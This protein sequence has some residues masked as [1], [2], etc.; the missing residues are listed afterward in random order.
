M[1]AVFRFLRR[2]VFALAIL[3]SAAVSFCFPDCFR[4]WGGVKLTSLVVPANVFSIWMNFSGSV[5]ANYWSRRP[6]EQRK[7][8]HV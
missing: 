3:G 2:Q 5:L 6:P 7:E 4:T 8:D 1:R